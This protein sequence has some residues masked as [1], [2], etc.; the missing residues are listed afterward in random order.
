[1]RFLFSSFV[2]FLSITVPENTLR[3]KELTSWIGTHVPN[4][5]SISSILLSD[6]IFI[7]NEDP[8]QLIRDFLSSL[9][10]IAENFTLLM[11]TKLI[12]CWNWRKILGSSAICSSERQAG[13]HRSS[14]NESEPD[15]EEYQ[16]L[17]IQGLRLKLNMLSN[18]RKDFEDYYT[19]IPVFG[20]NSSRCDLNLIKEYLLHHLLIEKNVVFP[21][22]FRMGNILAWIFLVHCFWTFETSGEERNLWTPSNSLAYEASEEKV[23]FP[24]EWFDSIEKLN[25][26]QLPP[27]E[28]VGSKLRNHNVLLH[29][30]DKFVQLKK[31]GIKQNEIWSLDSRKFPKMP[32][33]ITWSSKIFG[34]KK[35]CK[36]FANFSSDTTT[37]M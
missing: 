16:D 5:V 7:C 26:S 28:S 18:L 21:N 8:L 22:V 14:D 31:S 20:L 3:N 17:E 36:R 13:T 37:K 29:E 23:F 9:T 6:P 10:N 15:G 1:M 25:V 24:Y 4:S 32:K 35:S 33:I 34:K 11:R 30:Y 12:S 2:Q 27:I 19:T